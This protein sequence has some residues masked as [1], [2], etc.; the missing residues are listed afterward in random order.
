MAESG[1]K[2]GLGERRRGGQ[3]GGRGR[4]G[5]GTLVCVLRAGSE[6]G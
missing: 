5:V 4:S 2:E 6:M 1:G 3:G